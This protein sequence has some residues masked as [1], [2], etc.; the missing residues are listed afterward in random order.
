MHALMK[1]PT[2][3]WTSCFTGI[4]GFEHGAPN[5]PDLMVEWDPN[6]QTVLK[7]HY[8]NV[9]L[10]GDITDVRG[11]EVGRPAVM[12][13][14]FPCTNLSIGAPHREGLAGKDSH[15]FFEFTRLVEEVGRL[16]DWSDPEWV[17]VENTPGLLTSNNGRD[18]GTVLRVLGDLGYSVS[19][20]ILDAKGLGSTQRRKRVILV[21]HRG[22]DPRPAELVL[23]ITEG[24]EQADRPRAVGGPSLGPSLAGEPA[25]GAVVWRKSARARASLAE[26]GYET[27][28]ADGQA[29][30]LTGFDG[31]G[32]ARQ[33]H[34][35]AQGGGVRTLTFTEWERLQGFADGW[36]DGIPP[37]D[38][39]K[40][41]V[42]VRAG[43]YTIL[44]NALH[45]GTSKWVW[46]RLTAVHTNQPLL[47]VA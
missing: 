40:N 13:A 28:V 38:V 20:R 27:W 32:P 41:G 45:T 26:G 8:P 34:L 18:M 37:G 14:G 19:W 3:R 10:K 2:I 44:G 46:D 15:R 30:T 24:R 4:G 43:R 12:V 21:G 11:T 23:G 5:P 17:L 33:T 7:R 47:E 9:Q 22:A 39:R 35:L 31:G 6:C 1:P 36:T 29:N 25:Q 16:I 42:L